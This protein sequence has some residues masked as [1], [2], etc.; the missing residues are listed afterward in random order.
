MFVTVSETKTLQT[1]TIHTE[2]RKT[3]ILVLSGQE[4]SG[5]LSGLCGVLSRICKA[6][7]R[8]CWFCHSVWDSSRQ[9]HWS[10]IVNVHCTDIE[11]H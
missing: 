11:H 5:K 9:V 2:R 4:T 7:V 8:L 6:F 1:P 10:V 3:V